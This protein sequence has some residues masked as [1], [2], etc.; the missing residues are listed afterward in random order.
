MLEIKPIKTKTDYQSALKEIE[1]LFESTPNTPDGDRLEVWATLVESYEDEHFP[2]PEP[3]HVE[4]IR[5]YMESRGLAPKDLKPY[6]GDGV[7]VRQVL[8]RK[9]PLSITMIRKLHTGLGIPAEVLIQPYS[10]S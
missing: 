7:R 8:N 2:I 1:S 9:R 5:Y 10:L 3:D 6:I 4:A